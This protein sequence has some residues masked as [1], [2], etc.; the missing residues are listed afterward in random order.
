M[1]LGS[2]CTSAA[3]SEVVAWCE[4]FEL[5]MGH[6][7]LAPTAS[8]SVYKLHM[9]AYLICERLD[10]ARLLWRR[11]G[12]AL[13]PAREADVELIALWAIG[14]AMWAKDLAGAQAAM[15]AYGWS[16]PLLS[17]L[18]AQLQ[19]THLHASFDQCARA[20]SLISA[21]HLAATLGTRQHTH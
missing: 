7:P 14:K 12:A 11:L 2:L 13:G 8:L 1:A 20:Y 17:H 19:T 16:A 15:G 21:E 9:A 4:R 6:A 3:A 18:I 5:D 10:D